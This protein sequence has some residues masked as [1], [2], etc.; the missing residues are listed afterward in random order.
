MPHLRK[1]LGRII[2]VSSGFAVRPVPGLAAYCTSKAALNHF[3]KTFAEEEKG[4]T[5][6][7]FRPGAV[8]TTMQKVIR[9]KGSPRILKN[10]FDQRVKHHEKGELLSP[11]LPARAIAVLTLYAPREWSGNFV[12]WDDEDVQTLVKQYCSSKCLK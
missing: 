11:D 3:T 1:R 10:D 6:M 12:S 8:D 4:I 7:A 9:E 2:N 5:V